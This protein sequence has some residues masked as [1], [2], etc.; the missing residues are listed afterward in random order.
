MGSKSS[1]TSSKAAPAAPATGGAGLGA[2]AAAPADNAAVP[3]ASG[4]APPKVPGG[5]AQQ[6]AGVDHS[7]P[8]MLGHVAGASG[9]AAHDGVRVD[10]PMGQGVLV[11]VRESDGVNVVRLDFGA[12][13]YL[14]VSSIV[15]QG[16]CH[17]P[18]HSTPHSTNR[19]ELFFGDDDKP[20]LQDLL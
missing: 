15:G 16:C 2:G 14:Q 12:M 11:K 1:K 20:I 6:L 13:A 8:G 10:T 4:R 3:A 17:T 18:L 7:A 19:C 5:S 9:A